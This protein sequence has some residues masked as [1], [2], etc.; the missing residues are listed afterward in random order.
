[1]VQRRNGS[2]VKRYDGMTMRGKWLRPGS[3]ERGAKSMGRG[4]HGSGLRAES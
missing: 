2:K 3:G 4:A 1:M